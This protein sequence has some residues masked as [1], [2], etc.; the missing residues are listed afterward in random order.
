MKLIHKII[1]LTALSTSVYLSACEDAEIADPNIETNATSAKANFL[2][3]N[4]SPDAPS[5]DFFVDN[6]KTG[7]SLTAG[8]EQTAQ[9][10]AYTNVTISSNGVSTIGNINIR[11]KATS[12][13]IGGV[14]GSSDIILRAGNNNT[15]NILAVD[16]GYY[17]V[18]AVDSITR[19]KPLRKLDEGA[20]GDTTFV[21]R[22]T[23]EQIGV[24]EWRAL[25]PLVSNRNKLVDALGTVPLGSS[26]PGGPRFLVITDQLPLPSGTRFPKPAAGKCAVR[27]IMT[28][29]NTS[30]YTGTVT[31]TVGATAVTSGILVNQLSFANWSTTGVPS[32]GS[33]SNV[34]N[35]TYNTTINANDV[36][37]VPQNIVVMQ[38]AVELA[39]IN[40][41][42]F[43]ERGVYSI[44]LSGNR[45]TL[46]M[47][48]S[49]IK[50]K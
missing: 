46:P 22:K 3:V 41:Y 17:T 40:N 12:G 25:A 13:A 1:A 44:V 15:N 37:P 8:V 38:G 16:S 42:V 35:S 43:K 45:R 19:P 28:S 9:A 30:S 48:I 32:V 39:R 14:L 24:V 2:V 29:P 21:V 23:G 18:I 36:T 27:F 34:V 47:S 5:L 4:A 11:A 50:N 26:D 6:V 33:R 31:L 20:F 10:G 49:I 7:P